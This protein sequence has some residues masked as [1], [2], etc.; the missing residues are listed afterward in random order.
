MFPVMFVAQRLFQVI[1]IF[2]HLVEFLFESRRSARA[3]TCEI[4][5]ESG[6]A[7]TVPK[8]IQAAAKFLVIAS[9]NAAP[10]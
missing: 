10:L 9:G 3:R 1:L 4:P 6:C 5:H 7:A 8:L 2:G